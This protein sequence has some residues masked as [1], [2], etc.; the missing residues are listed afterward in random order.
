[1]IIDELVKNKNQKIEEHTEKFPKL[2]REDYLVKFSDEK[3]KKIE[4]FEYAQK[5]YE[6]VL[7]LEMFQKK[8]KE[9]YY[10][11]FNSST[12]QPFINQLCLTQIDFWDDRHLDAKTMP[13][14]HNKIYQEIENFPNYD[15]LNS[16]A[17]EMLIRTTEFLNLRDNSNCCSSDERIKRFDQLGIDINDVFKINKISEVYGH[18]KIKK[19]FTN[20][21]F[22]M[23][24]DALDYGLDRV[25]QFYINKKQIHVIDEV[26]KI[27][28][29]RDDE[30]N[31]KEIILGRTFKVVPHVT[32]EEVQASLSNYFIPTK[33][34]CQAQ[35]EEKFCV[36]DKNIP[37]VALEHDFLLSI[38][39]LIPNRIKGNIEFNFTRSLLRF[40]ELPIV[41]VP[42]NLNLSMQ[43]L[44]QLVA[45]L[46]SDFEEGLVE[47]PINI[48]YGT[49]YKFEKLNDIT[50]FKLT[51]KSIAEAFF[52]Y[53]LYK[54]IDEATTLHKAKLRRFK[55][56]DLEEIENQMKIKLKNKEDENNRFLDQHK[57]AMQEKEEKREQGYTKEEKKKKKKEQEKRR[58][59]IK[60]LTKDYEIENKK[61][62]IKF[63][64]EESA[65]KKKLTKKYKEYSLVYHPMIILE[66]I[67]I[68]HGL[69][70]YIC[71]QYLKFTRKYIDNLQY[72]E[73]I[74]GVKVAND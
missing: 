52:I 38:N 24:L 60:Q 56:I 70:P 72:K 22:T 14:L 41:D 40:K 28:L 51:R 46:K 55:E 7:M 68:L 6:D 65:E 69:T 20:S 33:F 26:N 23:T 12:K 45:K 43:E 21:Y 25:I 4:E 18:N 62:G 53:D 63:K 1:M 36:L 64:K 15:Y 5:P 54:F 34:N 42:L 44:I 10:E 29:N 61:A 19:N 32:V 31:K 66:N 37:L 8:Y 48:L 11:Y 3:Y 67:T 74:I 39:D 9:E 13:R 71:K 30:E 50:P 49:K 73:L 16:I 58:K 27:V 47:N 35:Q 57:Q 17:Y 2:G 59:R